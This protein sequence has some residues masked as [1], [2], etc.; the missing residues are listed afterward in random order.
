MKRY[1]I[2]KWNMYEI[3]GVLCSYVGSVSDI[4]QAS[5]ILQ[6]DDSIVEVI[7]TEGNRGAVLPVHGIAPHGGGGE[8]EEYYLPTLDEWGWKP[9]K[10]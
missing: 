10:P 3:G 8:I 6:H 7:D 5:D 1:L 9:L 4:G 2:F